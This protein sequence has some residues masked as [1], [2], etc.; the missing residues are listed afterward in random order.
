MTRYLIIII[1]SISIGCGSRE[2]II[3]IVDIGKSDRQG[4]AQ[5]LVATNKHSPKVVGLDFLLSTDSLD[6]DQQLVRIL[7]E[8]KNVVEAAALHKN[9]S[10]MPDTWNSLERYHEKFRFGEYAFSNITITEDSVIVDE[11]PMRQ[12]YKNEPVYA[13]CYMVARMY[14]EKQIGRRYNNFEDDITFPRGTIDR[15]FKIIRAGDL[16]AG[17]FDPK[18]IDGKIVLMGYVGR[19]EDSL[20]LNRWKTKKISGVEIHASFVRAIL[21]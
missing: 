4:I 13:F 9:D 6:K 19:D 17:D 3:T 10:S 12:F 20:Y 21:D 7:S 2:S 8:M 1:T 14:D 5:I 18:D 16:L 15:H 11:L